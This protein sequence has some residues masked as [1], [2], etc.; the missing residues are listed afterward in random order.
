[1]QQYLEGGALRP[2]AGPSGVYQAADGWIS[3]TVPRQH[4]WVAFCAAMDVAHLPDDPRFAMQDGRVENAEAMRAILRPIFATAAVAHWSERLVAHKVMH[5]RLNSYAEFLAHPHT[6]ASGAV[7]WVDHPGV[8]Q[9]M[10]LP[11]LAGVQAFGGGGARAIAPGLGEH[12][13]EIL[14]GRG[15]GANEIAEL[16]AQG[17]ARVPDVSA[18]RPG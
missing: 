5:E 11:N 18:S 12:T 2:P 10:P 3:V 14:R 17:V 4:E 8:P 15:F 16:L 13:V 9:L 1:M 6:A 7:A